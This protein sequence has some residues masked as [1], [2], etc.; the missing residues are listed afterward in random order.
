[1]AAIVDLRTVIAGGMW[2][3]FGY[4]A[5]EAELPKPR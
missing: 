2:P 1:M 5:A 3:A 4:I